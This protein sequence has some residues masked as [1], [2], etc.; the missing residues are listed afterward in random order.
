MEKGK[1]IEDLNPQSISLKWKVMLKDAHMDRRQF[2]A[3]GGFPKAHIKAWYLTTG[4]DTWS[5]R[6]HLMNKWH[7]FRLEKQKRIR[8][9]RT[10]ILPQGQGSFV[11]CRMTNYPECP[12]PT[13]SSLPTVLLWYIFWEELAFWGSPQKK[14]QWEMVHSLGPSLSTRL[15]GTTIAC[16]S[17]AVG[18][19]KRHCGKLCSLY[20]MSNTTHYRVN[21]CCWCIVVLFNRTFYNNRIP[22][23]CTFDVGGSLA[24]CGCWTYEIWLVCPRGWT[25]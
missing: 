4:W 25:F 7:R 15:L 9:D 23:S 2:G 8:Q 14:V 11:T 13:L 20:A 18:A 19:G 22:L 3:Q 21:E 6:S 16:E 5:L 1:S 12:P 17:E 10:P 24:P